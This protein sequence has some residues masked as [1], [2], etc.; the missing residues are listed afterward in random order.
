M[1]MNLCATK[2]H[3]FAQVSFAKNRAHVCTLDVPWQSETCRASKLWL[4]PVG[5]RAIENQEPPIELSD[6]VR[7]KLAPA[8]VAN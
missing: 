1:V 4:T 6:I 3:K 2:R 8:S 7:S 5:N